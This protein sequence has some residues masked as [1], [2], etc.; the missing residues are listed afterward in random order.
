MA[1]LPKTTDR[2]VLDAALEKRGAAGAGTTNTN[3]AARLVR[4]PHRASDATPQS[5]RG[6]GA[7]VEPAVGDEGSTQFQPCA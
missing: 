1:S 2:N 5:L 4:A 6:G 3:K 7:M